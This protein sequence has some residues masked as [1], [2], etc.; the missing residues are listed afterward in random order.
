V[1]DVKKIGSR[2]FPTKVEMIN[3]LR[4]DT[5]TVFEMNDVSFDVKLDP[6]IFSLQNCKDNNSSNISGG[7][8]SLS[9]ILTIVWA[10][11]RCVRTQARVGPPSI[12][13]RSASVPDRQD[14]LRR[15]SA[16]TALW[17]ALWSVPNACVRATLQHGWKVS[18][19]VEFQ[20]G[21]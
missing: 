9:Q 17:R 12:L 7:K 21:H 11:P 3:K 16:G 8:Y 6:S 14:R 13:G 15:G 18:A 2:Y 10:F 19:R 1:L 4:K 20:G 5:K